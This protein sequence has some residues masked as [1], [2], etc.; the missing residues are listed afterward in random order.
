MEEG[1]GL[2]RATQRRRSGATYGSRDEGS[3]LIR[4]HGGREGAASGQHG[5][6]EGN[7]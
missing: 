1:R 2:H 7:A 6:G 5:G 4:Q 3:C